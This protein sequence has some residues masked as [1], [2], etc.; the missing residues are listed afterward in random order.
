MALN[1]KAWYDKAYISVSAEDGNEVQLRAKTTSLNITGGNFD[2]E[3]IDT[4][5]GQIKR[6]GRRDDFEISFDGVATSN[7]DFDWIFHGK[8]VETDTSITSSSVIDYRICLLWTDQTGVTDA[9]QSITTSSEAYREIYAETN[10]ISCEKTMDAGEHLTASIKFKLPFED[11]G[12]E[13]NFKKEMCDTT[14][15]LSAVSSY[16]ST[17]KF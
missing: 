16:T 3:S 12:G 7:Q 11:S 10:M 15:T 17:N 1:K 14:S 4:F 5:G 8:T 2:I 13:I 9:S 6:I